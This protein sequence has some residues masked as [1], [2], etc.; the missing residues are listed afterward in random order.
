[1]PQ[2]Y[3]VRLQMRQPDS[4]EV[5]PIK[6]IRELGL[7]IIRDAIENLQ[8]LESKSRANRRYAKDSL[9][10]LQGNGRF[11]FWVQA[12]GLDPYWLQRQLKPILAK[13]EKKEKK[14]E[15]VLFQESYM[16]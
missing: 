1:M 12:S 6:A 3:R 11:D 13:H 7:Y 8:H 4:A 16:V 5:V 10:F 9:K 14:F 2:L 15:P